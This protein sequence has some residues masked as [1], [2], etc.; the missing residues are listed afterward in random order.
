MAQ[1]ALPQ[2][3]QRR[4]HVGKGRAVAQGPRLALDQVDVVLPVVA[5]AATTD[6]PLM[7]GDDG[8]IGHDADPIRIYRVLIMEEIYIIDTPVLIIVFEKVNIECSRSLLYSSNLSHPNSF[9]IFSSM[10][11]ESGC[12]SNIFV[13]LAS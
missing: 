6:E 11:G 2:S 9:R 10:Y 12:C 5:D 8:V 13:S 1:Q 7:A 4:R 3:L